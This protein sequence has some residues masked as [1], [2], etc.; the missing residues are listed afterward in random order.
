MYVC[1]ARNSEE[2]GCVF[3]RVSLIWAVLLD[4]TRQSVRVPLRQNYSLGGGGG[5]RAGHSIGGLS[6]SIESPSR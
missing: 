6:F 4:S 1:A 5:G 2:L 3:L